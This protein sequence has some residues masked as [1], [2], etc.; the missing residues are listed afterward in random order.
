MQE[1]Q[2]GLHEP[3]VNPAPP[4]AL[5]GPGG[6]LID[7]PTTL[8]ALELSSVALTLDDFAAAPALPELRRL[9]LS[10]SG[11][12]ERF[13]S[14]GAHFQEVADALVVSCPHLTAKSCTIMAQPIN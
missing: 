10:H 5:P 7:M 12:P 4:P 11:T 14:N 1:L 6:S 13:L 9:R 3:R 2:L 8:R